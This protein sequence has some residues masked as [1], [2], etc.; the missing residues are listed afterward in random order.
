VSTDRGVGALG[1]AQPREAP[2]PAD[3]WVPP[4]RATAED[5]VST[6]V[7]DGQLEVWSTVMC[8]NWGMVGLGLVKWEVGIMEVEKGKVVTA[9]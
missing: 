7:C 8:T 6:R 3:P 2:V 1:A 4:G 9:K 5:G